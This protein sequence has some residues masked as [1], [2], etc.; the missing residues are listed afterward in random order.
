LRFAKGGEGLHLSGMRA[1]FLA[2]FMTAATLA[3]ASAQSGY[4]GMVP[5]YS[6]PRSPY[7]DEPNYRPPGREPNR[8]EFGIG[9]DVDRYG[10]AHPPHDDGRRPPRKPNRPP[11]P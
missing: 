11:R 2:L 3:T 6:T 5:R 4:D 8:Y 7:F 1:C 10:N 9:V